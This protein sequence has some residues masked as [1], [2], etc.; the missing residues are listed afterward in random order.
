MSGPP[1][2]LVFPRSTGA[3]SRRALR[4]QLLHA[5]RE[6][7]SPV[8]VDLSGSQTLDH[9][10]IDLLLDCASLVI[11]RDARLLLVAGSSHIQVLLDVIRLSS[12]VPV[13][14][15]LE[16]ALEF[17]PQYRPAPILAEHP[18]STVRE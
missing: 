16:E 8:I 5:L 11:G 18:I 10:D 2:I 14:K 3:A 15:S 1:T 4:R 12:L 6:S 9:E 13:L 7:E 17:K